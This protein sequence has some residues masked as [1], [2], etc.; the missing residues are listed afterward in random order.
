MKIGQQLLQTSVFISQTARRHIPNDH[1]MDSYSRE[2][3]KRHIA[4]IAC[5]YTDILIGPDKY[6]L[7]DRI[8]CTR[9]CLLDALR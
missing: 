9:K 8:D 1:N 5:H 3:L 6:S 7:L 2:N 4:C